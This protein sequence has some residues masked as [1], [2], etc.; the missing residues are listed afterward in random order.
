V[1]CATFELAGVIDTPTLWEESR[2]IG[3]AVSLAFWS[4]LASQ[5]RLC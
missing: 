4:R 3:K 1:E 5:Q 2:C